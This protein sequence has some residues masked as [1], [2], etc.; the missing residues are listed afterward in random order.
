MN[1]STKL[2][3]FQ[4][5]IVVGAVGIFFIGGLIV[6]FLLFDRETLSLLLWMD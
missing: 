5:A 1:E 2:G 4:L 3:L 6:I